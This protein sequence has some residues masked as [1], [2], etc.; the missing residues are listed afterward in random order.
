[1]MENPN[2]FIEVTCLSDGMRASLR[3]ENIVSVY[4]VGEEID[5][6]A[7]RPAHVQI[8]TS[9]G[10]CLRVTDSYDD[11]KQKIWKAEL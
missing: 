6:G 11:V 9:N 5:D 3:A 4:E 2:G 1:M 8:V 10:S 7:K